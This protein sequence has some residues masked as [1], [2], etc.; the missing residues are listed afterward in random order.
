MFPRSIF[1]LAQRKATETKAPPRVL[2]QNDMRMH[3][4]RSDA[5]LSTD[6]IFFVHSVYS[7]NKL[8]EGPVN[9][10]YPQKKKG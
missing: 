4:R 8:L 10:G 9:G 2:S 7:G 1:A 3:G 6:F 5:L